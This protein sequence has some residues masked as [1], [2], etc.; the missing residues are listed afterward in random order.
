MISHDASHMFSEA[1]SENKIPKKSENCHFNSEGW[2]SPGWALIVFLYV[3]NRLVTVKKTH[4][5]GVIKSLSV[6]Q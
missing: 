1:I 6:N 5:Q 3:F 4:Q 2:F